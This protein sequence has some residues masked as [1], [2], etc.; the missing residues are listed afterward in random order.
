MFA[1][2]LGSHYLSHAP[3]AVASTEAEFGKNVVHTDGHLRPGH[4]ETIW[5]RG[6]PGAGRTE[7]SFFP[8]AICG[9]GCGVA[10]RK[11]ARTN[12]RGAA[13]F[14]VRVPGTFFNAEEKPTYFRDR[15]RINLMVLWYGPDD[16]D[17]DVGNAD[18][19]PVIIRSHRQPEQ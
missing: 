18:P 6:F 3:S 4:L 17:F 13:K 7:V 14:Q 15:E 16:D 1:V 8:T 11:G 19:M 5:I 9:G 2:C 10:S 12:Q